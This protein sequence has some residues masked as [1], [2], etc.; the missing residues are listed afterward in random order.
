MEFLELK[1]CRSPGCR[2]HATWLAVVLIGGLFF[3]V[4][5]FAQKKEKKK[6][7]QERGGKASG[8]RGED[9]ARRK[10]AAESVRHTSQ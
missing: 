7:E 9:T 3:A 6:K 2:V 4:P 8:A 1:V 10:C 5:G